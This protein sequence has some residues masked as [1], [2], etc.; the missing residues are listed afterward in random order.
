MNGHR[1]TQSEFALQRVVESFGNHLYSVQEHQ[2]IHTYRVVFRSCE[3]EDIDNLVLRYLNIGALP[4]EEFPKEWLSNGETRY[5]STEETVCGTG[6][7][8]EFVLRRN[9]KLSPRIRR[10][11]KEILG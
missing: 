5:T 1:Y 2:L 11:E 10:G 9:E 4:F 6:L 8:C 7:D 3:L